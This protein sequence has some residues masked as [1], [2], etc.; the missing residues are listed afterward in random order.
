MDDLDALVCCLYIANHS[1]DH[2]L[3]LSA[4]LLVC[5][6]SVALRYS[7]YHHYAYHSFCLLCFCLQNP[8]LCA[9]LAELTIHFDVKP[10][11]WWRSFVTLISVQYGRTM[12]SCWDILIRPLDPST[13]FLYYSAYYTRPLCPIPNTFIHARVAWNRLCPLLIC[14]VTCVQPV[15]AMGTARWNS[16]VQWERSVLLNGR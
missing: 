14:K 16:K 4:C 2:S 10:V 6:V 15:V 8:G 13:Y 12:H 9:A 11:I 7:L 1:W 3:Q 5:W